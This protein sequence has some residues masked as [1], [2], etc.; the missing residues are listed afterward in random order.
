MKPYFLLA[1]TAKHEAE[2][3]LPQKTGVM[4]MVESGNTSSSE[5]ITLHLSSGVKYV[6]QK[7]DICFSQDDDKIY[8]YYT[9]EQDSLGRPIKKTCY[10]LGP[11]NTQITTDEY[12]KYYTI[13][14]YDKKGKLINEFSYNGKGLDDKW[15]TADDV[16]IYHT[17]YEY[18]SHRNKIKVVR[19]TKDDNVFDYTTFKNNPRGLI[20][21]DVVYKGKG[22]DNKW[23][24]AD[25]EIEKYHRFEY[26]KNDNLSR[27]M[28]YSAQYNGKG[29]DGLW[30]TADDIIFATKGFLVNQNGSMAGI[31]KYIAPGPDNKWFTADDV[32]QY[33]TTYNTTE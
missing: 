22:P 4:E 33:Y 2:E 29:P 6:P 28:E 24:T 19:C 8:N 23:L 26:D 1:E 27:A 3:L 18:D 20:I 7:D 31:K 10:N 5:K 16:Q 17:H 32:L 25:D 30:F 9:F 12:I 14:K 11:N 13:Y 15:F 21:M